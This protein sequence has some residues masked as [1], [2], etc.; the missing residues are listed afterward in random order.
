MHIHTYVYMYICTYN[1]IYVIYIFYVILACMYAH[2]T[3]V[4]ME[5]YYAGY[6]HLC[7]RPSLPTSTTK[8]SHTG[9]S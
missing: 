7:R 5:L 8:Y 6:I 3:Y 1:I 4:Y 9:T 2:C